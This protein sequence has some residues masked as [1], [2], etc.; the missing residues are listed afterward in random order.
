[1][2]E[3]LWSVLIL[4]CVGLALAHIVTTASAQPSQGES[5]IEQTFTA[6]GSLQSKPLS[7]SPIDLKVDSR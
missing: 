1:M 7:E 4:I 5:V 6:N 3:G 2:I